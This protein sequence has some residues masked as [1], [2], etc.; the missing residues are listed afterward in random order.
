MAKIFSLSQGLIHRLE[1]GVT[2][3]GIQMKYGKDKKFDKIKQGTFQ[4]VD[5]ALEV[6]CEGCK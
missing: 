1:E 3:C 4:E 6:T 5:E 2:K